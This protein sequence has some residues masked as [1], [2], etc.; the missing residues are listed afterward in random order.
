MTS[1]ITRRIS[2]LTRSQYFKSKMATV[3]DVTDYDTMED[4]IAK[5]TE[6]LQKGN[7]VA[8]PTDTIYG[9]AA[10]AQNTEA[11]NKIYEIKNRANQKPVAICVADVKDVC[12]WGKVTVSNDLLQE[13]LPG[14]V[15]LVF[16][17]TLSLNPDLNPATSLVGIR[18]PNCD[19]VRR[20]AR[21]C[22]EPLA[23]T[24]A[25]ISSEESPLSAQEFSHLF[26]KID[27]VCDGGTLSETPESRFG[28]TVIRLTTPGKYS[29][30]RE[31]SAY[32]ATV[33]LLVN[34][35]NLEE[36]SFSTFI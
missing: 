22:G 24:S 17:R 35:Y 10:L 34:K 32:K 9:L 31:G 8:V 28:S 29:I 4:H 27:I 25:N 5:T 26:N 16:E 19:F 7:I 33:N 13:L 3:L 36:E 1:V 30:I 2:Q 23:L 21:S 12:K 15:T 14:P 6:S 18:I 11:V 20:L